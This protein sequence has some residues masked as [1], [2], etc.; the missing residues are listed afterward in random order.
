V[1]RT[2]RWY[3]PYGYH[4]W[5][6][7][8]TIYKQKLITQLTP[9]QLEGFLTILSLNVSK[10]EYLLYKRLWNLFEYPQ[11]VLSNDT[12]VLG[13]IEHHSKEYSVEDLVTLYNSSLNITKKNISIL[14]LFLRDRDKISDKSLT[15][16]WGSGNHKDIEENVLNHYLKHVVYDANEQKHWE[17]LGVR[18]LEEYRSYP[19]KHFYSMVRVLI[20][21]NGGNAYLSGFYGNVFV[22]GRYIEGKFGISSTYYV[23]SGE[24]EGRYINRCFD[25]EFV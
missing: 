4:K 13:K 15:I 16:E 18:T 24:K 14:M 21:S 8:E 22:V 19:I 7:D 23:E 10:A 12:S 1:D 11:V 6:E 5:L 9:S 25:L 3:N 17:S 2:L 20:H